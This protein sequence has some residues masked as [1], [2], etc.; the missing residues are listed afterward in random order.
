MLR[1][2]EVR[3]PAAPNPPGQNT[4]QQVR[5]YPD[6]PGLSGQDLEDHLNAIVSRMRLNAGAQDW[7]QPPAPGQGGTG[8]QAI[9]G[10]QPLGERDG[11]NL[12]FTTAHPFVP[13]T[14]RV[15]L[16]GLRQALAADGSADFRI[17]ESAGPGSGYDTLLLAWPPLDRDRILVDYQRAA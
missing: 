15:E 16:N 8:A 10:E 14:L 11:E 6:Q 7:R 4:E 5:A 9:V 2:F 3:G 12:A 13:Q 17:A 1:A